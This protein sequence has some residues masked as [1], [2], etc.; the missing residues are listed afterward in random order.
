MAHSSQ[1]FGGFQAS[2]SLPD[3]TKLRM[4]FS[5]VP[6]ARIGFNIPVVISAPVP[7]SDPE[8]DAPSEV[9]SATVMAHF[10]TGASITSIDESLAEHLG[11]VPIGVGISH[12]AGGETQT[13]NYV[14]DL[15]FP[16]SKLSPFSN[17]R[18]SSCK[19]GYDISGKASPQNFGLLLGRDVMTR[20]NI[21]W[22]GPTSSV[23]ISD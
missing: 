21:V 10:D 4:V 22:N 2:P 3:G 12:T 23:F 8:Q 5:P 15:S 16:N 7:P 20:W 17:L 6:L 18:I 14:I 11:L 1:I 13:S 19:L 9:K